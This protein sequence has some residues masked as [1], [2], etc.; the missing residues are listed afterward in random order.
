[1]VK[2]LLFLS[3]AT[4]IS[5]TACSTIDKSVFLKIEPVN[6]D[7]V[8]IQSGDYKKYK[9]QEY[10]FQYENVS[11]VVHDIVLTTG[12]KEPYSWA[13][14]WGPPFLPIFWL[15]PTRSY[16]FLYKIEI[17]SLTNV[18]SVNLAN[19]KVIFSGKN[20][21]QPSVALGDYKRSS[22]SIRIKLKDDSCVDVNGHRICPEGTK[23]FPPQT[24]TISNEKRGYKIKYDELPAKMKEIFVDLGYIKIDDKEVKLPIIRYRRITKYRFR[25][26]FQA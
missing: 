10:K 16:D 8:Q 11:V 2:R 1:M 13:A 24:V 23:P 7:W 15:G 14:F 6:A 17:E 12:Y 18:T 19:V 5:F 25:L 22:L 4:A 26:I 9:F 21:I 3:L 20:S